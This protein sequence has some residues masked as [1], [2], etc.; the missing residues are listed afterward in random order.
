MTVIA[1]DP[2][3][4][5]EDL[6]AGRFVAQANYVRVEPN[7]SVRLYAHVPFRIRRNEGCTDACFEDAPFVP[8]RISLEQARFAL[9]RGS[10]VM[11][12]S[13]AEA[14]P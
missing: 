7:V 9:A 11:V 10:V 8:V 2:S 3:M 13:Q 14:A 6:L 5:D 1:Y 4:T 12:G